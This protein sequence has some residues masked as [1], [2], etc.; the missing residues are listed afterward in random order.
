VLLM[1]F[2]SYIE[3]APQ[4]TTQ[5]LIA[6]AVISLLFAVAFVV[7]RAFVRLWF[8]WDALRRR[9]LRWA[10]THALL[11]VA[12]SGAV[13]VGVALFTLI[14]VFTRPSAPLFQWITALIFI[15]IL[16]A[17][18]ILLVLPPSALF[19]Y[20]FARGA[21]RR[22][23]ALAEA[24]ERLRSG[25]YTAR[26][27]V[28]GED[29]VARLQANFNAMATDLERGVRDLRAERDQVATLLAQRRELIASVSH[30]LRTPVATLRG[31]L[32]SASLRWNDNVTPDALRHDVD[33]MLH[34]T[35][36]LQ[37]LIDDLFTLARAEVGRLDLR[38]TPTDLGSLTRGAVEAVAPLAW[39][40]ARVEV[41][42]RVS[43]DLPHALI[44]AT[45]TEQALHNLLRNALRHTPPGGIIVVV[46]ERAGDCL[47]LRVRDTGVGI[48]A[49]D[50]PHIWERFFRGDGARVADANGAG[51]GLALVKEVTE[52]MGGKVDVESE[53][54]VGSVFS[55]LLPLSA[56]SVTPPL[57]SQA[58]PPEQGPT[59]PE[60]VA[61]VS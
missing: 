58:S 46:A 50:L 26:S 60:R 55:L 61:A 37:G 9:S 18:G 7:Y 53:S 21:S 33:V 13:L 5:Y 56:A 28:Q 25:D 51:L 34:E 44:D 14:F 3:R 22:I 17:A 23:L 54:G 32:E 8:W 39:R 2:R 27:P 52:A 57:A 10:L 20:L 36:R 19:S 6:E 31:Y 29:E 40:D 42:A 48:S 38:C 45:R 41:V 12:A 4:R 47:A 24:T 30:E 35:V 15:S 43:P 11:T 59:A 1:L 16:I 49:D